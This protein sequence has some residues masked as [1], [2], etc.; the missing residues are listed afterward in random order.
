MNM[1]QRD[2]KASTEQGGKPVNHKT[3]GGTERMPPIDLSA[4]KKLLRHEQLLKIQNIALADTFPELLLG[5][6]FLAEASKQLELLDHFSALMIRP[7]P[8]NDQA[9]NTLIKTGLFFS[10]FD[11]VDHVCKSNSGFWGIYDN[12]CVACFFETKTFP[13]P[14]LNLAEKI[15]REMEGRENI[16]VS[17][18]IAFYPQ[19]TYKKEDII[20]NARKALEHAHL[21]GH[22]SIVEFDSVS[23]NISGDKL[24]QQGNIDGAIAEFEKALLL[25]PENVNVFNSLG[26]CFGVQGK[27]QTAIDMFK[28]VMKIAPDDV[29]APYNIGLAYLMIGDKDKAQEFFLHAFSLDQNQLEVVI[30]IGRIYLEKKDPEKAKEYFKKA[31]TIDE[32][33]GTGHRFLGEC[34]SKLNRHEK[35]I[36]S[37]VKAIKLNANDA[38]SLSALACLY[39]EQELNRD[40]AIV[41]G[42]QSVKLSPATALFRQRLGKVYFMFEMFD[43]ALK[44]FKC[45]TEL[46]QDCESFILAI[47]NREKKK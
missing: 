2:G 36:N 10:L 21:S 9:G 30:H 43:E 33:S 40:I 35:A 39:A 22:N 45:A 37:Y 41:F 4:D 3:N 32:N 6:A 26:V 27:H 19:L 12:D 1:K 17:T 29:M 23:L 14:A 44:E 25:D 18:G 47:Q 13:D 24:Y 34:Y 11:I 16:T 7:D 28:N 38:H 20:E 8:V 42:R 5:E 15:H 46:G 31:V